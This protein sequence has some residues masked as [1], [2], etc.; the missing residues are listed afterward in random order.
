[1]G[2]FGETETQ[3]HCV[4]VQGVLDP[5]EIKDEPCDDG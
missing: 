4:A 5:S 1:M 3:G 2:G